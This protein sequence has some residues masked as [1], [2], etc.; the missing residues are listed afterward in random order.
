MCKVELHLPAPPRWGRDG[1][2]IPV[3][4]PGAYGTLEDEGLDCLLLS[5]I[6]L[7]RGGSAYEESELFLRGAP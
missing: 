3:I 2:K 7:V 6:S 4:N 5:M 1:F